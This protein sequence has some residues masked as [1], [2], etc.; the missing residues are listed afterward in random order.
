VP[1]EI[2]TKAGYLL[3]LVNMG[4][5]V[6]SAHL[7]LKTKDPEAW[8]VVQDV[9]GDKHADA[10][11]AIQATTLRAHKHWNSNAALNM[12]RIAD[13]NGNMSLDNFRDKVSDL[14]VAMN[15]HLRYQIMVY[16]TD[17]DDRG[18]GDHN[19]CMG[20]DTA[21]SGILQKKFEGIIAYMDP[22][23]K[24]RGNEVKDDGWLK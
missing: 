3:T 8:T 2:L 17:T 24:P 5:T 16:K 11:K 10:I 12:K 4:I 20:Y 6:D 1:H 9:V 22:S 23:E 14:A 13:Q 19:V 15:P 7:T 18:A 21:C